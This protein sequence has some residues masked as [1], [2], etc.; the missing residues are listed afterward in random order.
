[1]LIIN[2]VKFTV[3]FGLLVLF[4]LIYGIDPSPAWLAL[5]PLVAIQFLLI[6]AIAGLV[7]ALVPFLPDLRLMLDQLLTLLFFLS[8]IFFDISAVSGRLHSVLMLN[9]MAVLIESYRTVLIDGQWPAALPLV[10]VGAV[11]LLGIACAG[12][13]LKHYDRIYPKVLV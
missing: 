3:I 12:A 8:G 9:P 11:S 2:T 4:L 6:A 13:V 10:L 7:S 1:M 5:P